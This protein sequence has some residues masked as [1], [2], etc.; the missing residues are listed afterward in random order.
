[1]AAKR[2]HIRPVSKVFIISILLA[3]VVFA[4]ITCYSA[5]AY[6]RDRIVLQCESALQSVFDLY[7]EKVYSLSEL[8]VPIF[9]TEANEK[10][11]RNYFTRSG[12]ASLSYDERINLAMLLNNMMSRD[13]DIHF[14]ALYNA[15]ADHNYC[16][17]EN[18]NTLRDMWTDL[19]Q[20]SEAGSSR[21]QL[22]SLYTWETD[23][24]EERHSFVIQ[25]GSVPAGSNDKIFIGYD[26][27]AFDRAL[28]RSEVKDLATFVVINETGLIYDSSG[29]RYE[30]PYDVSWI[31]DESAVHRDLDGAYWFTDAMRNTGRVFTAAYM[32]PWGELIQRGNLYTPFILLILVAFTIF[33]L[34]L[35]WLSAKRIFR[36]VEHIQE[37]LT[38]LGDNRLEHRLAVSAN[39]DEF[40]EIAANVNAMAGRLKDSIEKETEL[41]VRET[42][43]ELNQIQARF[44]P[45]FL[46]NT[47]E[48]IRGKLFRTGDLETA[49]YIEKLSRIF[50]NLT[51]AAPVMSIREEIAFCSLYMSLLQL[52]FHDAVDVSY[53][54]AAELQDCGILAHLIQPAIENYF[55]HA[56]DETTDYHT[57]DITCEAIG[58]DAVQ[59]VIADNGTGSDDERIGQINQR[60]LIPV[61]SDRGYG[62]MSIAK[63]IRFFYGEGYGVHLEKNEPC[64]MKV[65]ITIPRMSVDAHRRKLGISD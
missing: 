6:Q 49:D 32:I 20:L 29:L 41:R 12:S 13:P 9:Q 50:R 31:V 54:I 28:R 19:P 23:Y 47:L 46:Y 37:G 30:E 11:M 2:F 65:V 26:V 48:V 45:H 63:R 18:S 58:E 40:D 51:D 3:L 21:Q 25:G 34:I 57:L 59:I 5:Y 14:I 62:L 53:D 55:M 61:I 33:S 15:N 43:A 44:D 27:G 64:G 52:R 10:L 39:G 60:L 17:T 16:L 8:Y 36:R 4:G 24:Y 1:M 22:L 38:V 56:L 42:A 35:Y 7:Y